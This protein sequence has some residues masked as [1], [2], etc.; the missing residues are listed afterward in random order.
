M[1]LRGLEGQ[2]DG[3]ARVI[4]QGHEWR[5]CVLKRDEIE[6]K[7]ETKKHTNRKDDVQP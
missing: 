6:A 4:Q 1:C 7:M 5:F 3:A 2:T